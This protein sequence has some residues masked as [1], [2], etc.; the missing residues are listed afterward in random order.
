MDHSRN[1]CGLGQF[2][3]DEALLLQFY[4]GWWCPMDISFFRKLVDLQDDAELAHARFVSVS[5]DP[6]E[7]TAPFRMG[8][9]ARWSFLCDP[10]RTWLAELEIGDGPDATCYAPAIFVLRPDL[11]VHRAYDGS[12][13]WGRPTMEQLR[14]DFRE[15]TMAAAV[16]DVPAL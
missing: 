15:I 3:G 13:F 14:T 8:L 12:S 2:A 16:T 7:T 6:P 11:V 4:R 10:D 1:R 9:G 5:V